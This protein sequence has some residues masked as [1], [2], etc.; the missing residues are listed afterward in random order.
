MN[1]DNSVL[2]RYCLLYSFQVSLVVLG[3][4]FDNENAIVTLRD[5]EMPEGSA[6]EGTLREQNVPESS[7]PAPLF[8]GNVSN[9]MS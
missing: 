7:V 3:L 5:Q 2:N 6:L 8:D 4:L 1:K 9:A